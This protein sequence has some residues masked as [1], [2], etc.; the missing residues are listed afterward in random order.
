M[1]CHLPSQYLDAT[2]GILK[3]IN[4]KLSICSFVNTGN[5]EG[6][7]VESLLSIVS[8]PTVSV[9]LTTCP[10]AKEHFGSQTE[11]EYAQFC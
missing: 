8:S 11:F 9:P 3:Q 6:H 1:D 7:F 4:I 2:G 5:I 10:K